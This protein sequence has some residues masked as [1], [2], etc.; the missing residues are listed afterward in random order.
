M[1]IQVEGNCDARFLRVR[2]VFESSF[3]NGL[4]VGAAVSA[5]INSKPVV[6]LWGG[7]ADAA[8]TRPW[9]RDTLVNVYSTTK[10]I[11]AIL[12]H[13][14]VEQGKLDLDAPVA[15][16]WPEFAQA[17]KERIPVNYLLSHR[18]GLPAVR[19]QLPPDAWVKWRVMCEAL[20]AETPWW[21]PGTRHGYHALTF[22]Y[23][24]G[25]VMHRVSGRTPGTYLRD[26]IAAPNSLDIHI[27]VDASFDPRIAE[28]VGAK[29]PPPDA[30]PSLLTEMASDPES[31]TYKATANPVPVLD[32]KLVNSH[33]WRAAEIPAA[34]GHA[35]A[36]D[37][38]RLYGALATGGSLDGRRILTP[39]SIARASTEQAIGLDVVLGVKTRW[40]LG[41]ALTQP[42][43]PLGPNPRAFGH[44]GAGGSL[45]FADPDARV[46]FG[47]T[48]NQ[49][50]SDALLDGRAAALFNA[51]YESL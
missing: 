7:H 3:A 26:E 47:Y 43:T 35:T 46:G 33:A 18:A 1:A 13:R 49:M 14:L 31:I 40:G 36:R 29:P 38:A 21:E 34:N 5:T 39:A 19:K 28:L 4:E 24:V 51:L 27:G 22:G 30:P 42:E 48:M 23:L 2:E 16:Y 41:F 8:R 50:G 15:R 32:P 11:T 20:A 37:L 17:G 44:P 12:A 10:G 9:K 25:E 45:G 6:D